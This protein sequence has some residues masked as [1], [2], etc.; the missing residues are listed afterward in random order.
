MEIEQNIW[1]FTAEGEA[2]VLYKMTN[3]G[4]AS[5]KLTNI[6][7]T[8]VSVEVPDPGRPARERGPRLRRFQKL[9]RRRAV[10]GENGRAGFAN[11]IRGAKFTLDGVEYR[12]SA[13]CSEGRHH[14]H[15]GGIN[16]FANKIWESRVETDR[17]VFSLFS[18][19][20]DQG[21]PAT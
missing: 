18:P 7:A 3:A 19:D 8:V 1:G 12:L 9:F 13:N 16:G 20:G 10:H 5:V 4:G 14:T 2:I 17:V 15:G 11:R 6:G 21:Y